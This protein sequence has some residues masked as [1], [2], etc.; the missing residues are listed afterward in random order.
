M[1]ASLGE[2]IAARFPTKHGPPFGTDWAVVDRSDGA[3][4][5]ILTWDA[6]AMGVASPD[7]ATIAAWR[8]AYVPAVFNTPGNEDVGFFPTSYLSGLTLAPASIL[9][10]SGTSFSVARGLCNV[11]VAVTAVNTM[12]YLKTTIN[13]SINAAW[14]VG[15]T[16]GAMDTGSV[17]NNTWY[18]VFLIRR[19][20][21][22]VTDVLVSTNATT[23]TLPTN[24]TQQRRIGSFKTNAT[25]A[26]IE[27][28]QDGDRFMWRTPVAEFSVNNPG[29]AQVSRALA[30]VPLGVRVR[31]HLFVGASAVAADAGPGAIYVTD[32]SLNDVAAAGTSAASMLVYTDTRAGGSVL[33]GGAPVDVM[34]DVSQSIGTRLQL[35]STNITFFGNTNGWTDR[36][37]QDT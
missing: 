27:F 16:N 23:P 11:D 13:K 17:A 8:A 33:L 32:L 35:S 37:G 19:P 21:T 15:N 34:T 22:G 28:V 29:A 4:E 9:G 6:A 5:V 7:A 26:I 3:G 20:D 30:G 1:A 18:H 2:V 14:A 25:P 36:R 31:A 10:G 24:Y 12:M